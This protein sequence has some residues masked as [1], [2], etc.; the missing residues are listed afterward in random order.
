MIRA[1]RFDQQERVRIRPERREHVT[2]LLHVLER[3][4]VEVAR[5]KCERVA[6]VDRVATRSVSRALLQQDW[7]DIAFEIRTAGR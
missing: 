6:L 1:D 2:T 5:G 7:L 3:R 4:D